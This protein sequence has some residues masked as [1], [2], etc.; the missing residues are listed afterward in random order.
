MPTARQ[1]PLLV[2]PPSARPCRLDDRSEALLE[3]FRL[4]RLAAGAHP[5]SAAREVSQLRSVARE[6]GTA[7]D[8]LPLDRLVADI[9][10]VARALIEPRAKIARSTNR[11][12]FW[13]VQQFIQVVASELDAEPGPVFE[14]L[15]ALLPKAVAPAWHRTGI[16]VAGTTE[17]RRRRA[18]SMGLIELRAIVAAVAYPDDP[19]RT[20]RDRAVVA[21]HCFSGLRPEEICGLAWGNLTAG[22]STTGRDAWAASVERRGHHVTL[23]V[24][25]P[26]AEAVT[27]L[28]YQ[29]GGST[30]ELRGPIFRATASRPEPISY[31]S[32]RAI[33]ANACIGAG[34]PVTASVQLR[35]A[36]GY[37]LRTRGLSDHEVAAALGIARVRTVDTLLRPHHALSAQRRT[38]EVLG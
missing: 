32:A 22:S 24:L 13:A 19:V 8:P 16:V 17:R 9:R 10:S 6:A 12:R 33:V 27:L 11:A 26:A 1:L 2:E 20:V 5:R 31:R 3:R 21:L 7:D 25:G 29:S 4:A 23:P 35:A 36:F 37:W 18:P 15:D 34:L 38:R 14:A 28:A 30:E